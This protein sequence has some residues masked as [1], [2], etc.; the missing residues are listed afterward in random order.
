MERYKSKMGVV[1]EI[2]PDADG[3]LLSVV[4]TNVKMVKRKEVVSERKQIYLRSG[5][6]DCFKYMHQVDV[7]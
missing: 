7:F 6:D 1:Y 5:Y 2:A 3:Y 4:H